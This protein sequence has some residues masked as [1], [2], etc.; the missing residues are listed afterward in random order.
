MERLLQMT[1]ISKR[2][3]ANVVLSDV[4][5]ELRHGEVHALIGEN[6]AGKST[7]MKILMGMY[8][9]D[10]GSI[11]VEGVTRRFASPSEA[12][13]AGIAMIHQE[14][15]LVPEMTIAENIFLGR[16]KRR[17]GLIDRAA[18]EAEAGEHLRT[19]GMTLDPAELVRNLSVSE[20]QMVEIAKTISCNARIIIMDEPTSA[21]TD[22]EVHRLFACI[23]VLQA[24]G[25]GIIY[26]SHKMDELFTISDRITVLRDGQYIG[27]RKTGEFDRQDLIRMMVGREVSEVFPSRES[28]PGDEL[29]RVEHLSLR[30]VFEDVSF[31]L[32]RGEILG[33]AGLMGAGRSEVAMTLFGHHAASSGTIRI[34]GKVCTIRAPWD[35]IGH[36]IALVSEDRKRF[37]LNLMAS[38]CDNIVMVIEAGLGRFGLFNRRAAVQRAERMIARLG[39]KTFHHSQVVQSLSGGNQQKV[40]L[41]KWLLNEPEIIIFDEPTRGIDVGAKAEIYR[42]IHEIVNAG[43]A[44]LLI[45]SEMPELIGL[46]DRVLVMCAGRKTGE[47]EGANITQENI[48][49]LASHGA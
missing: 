33:L 16:E 18:Q 9:A 10:G 5:F 27:T 29:L 41:A 36:R 2:F 35:A 1:A 44:V 39:I 14:L 40:V 43:K 34:D 49:N 7:L 38:V 20:M 6:G 31:V 13:R 22:E 17:Y 12:L 4:K 47:L 42:L 37:G 26:I 30:G 46:A 21:I 28:A 23:R 25:I 19:L 24:R 48:M 3:G 8:R 15:N 11:Q 45:S 32:R